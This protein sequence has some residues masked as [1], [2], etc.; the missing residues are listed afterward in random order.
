[1]GL[2]LF[3]RVSP[4]TQW[5][6]NLLEI[7][8]QEQKSILF[9]YFQGH[10]FGAKYGGI[11]SITLVVTYCQAP[12][13]WLQAYTLAYTDIDRMVIISKCG[14][15][16][17]GAPPFA[18]IV[19]LPTNVGRCDQTYAYWISSMVQTEKALL[20]P[21]HVLVFIKD[22]EDNSHIPH[23][24][25]SFSN[26]VMAASVLGFSCQASLTEWD[27]YRLSNYVR[28]RELLKTAFAQY[29]RK[30]RNMVY[31]NSSMGIFK[32]KHTNLGSWLLSMGLD[33]VPEVAQV[34]F[35]GNFAVRASN[36]NKRDPTVWI[37][38]EKSISRGDSVEEGHF[39]ERSWGILL[40]DPIG[41]HQTKIL[42]ES[43]N[44]L[45]LKRDFSLYGILAKNFQAEDSKIVKKWY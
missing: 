42:A 15:P 16:V 20:T 6:L 25:R 31:H 18:D 32:S 8:T 28:T 13:H 9:S 30:E 26:L 33:S 14:L 35:G 36:L 4:G 11:H 19:E 1:V 3:L 29:E 44:I 37:N 10:T 39:A 24:R 23:V 21:D 40:A 38:I 43:S 41:K 45:I 5:P 2:L 22:N 12:L 17:V 34:C 27:T 7:A